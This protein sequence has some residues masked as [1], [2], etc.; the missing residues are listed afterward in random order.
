MTVSFLSITV[1]IAAT[2]TL[3][4]ISSLRPFK[5]SQLE[6]APAI[7]PLPDKV[8]GR[9]DLIHNIIKKILVSKGLQHIAIAITGGP[10][11]G[12]TWVA[13]A[14]LNNKHIFKRFRAARHWVECDQLSP[15][16]DKYAAFLELVSTN[17]NPHMPKSNDRLR[18]IMFYL[19]KHEVPRIVA[20]DNFETIWEPLESR[21]MVE[22]ALHHLA[23]VPRLTILLTSRDDGTPAAGRVTWQKYAIEP[24]SHDAAK[25][26]WIS[27]NGKADDA[28]DD[29]LRAIDGHPL[30][31]VRLAAYA[32]GDAMMPSSNSS[33]MLENWNNGKT[34]YFCGGNDRMNCAD[35]SLRISLQS[36][37]MKSNPEAL[38]LL[39]IIAFLP[40]GIR[41]ENLKVVA[42]LIDDP[43]NAARVLRQ[44]SLAYYRSDVLQVHETTR[45][46]MIHNERPTLDPSHKEKVQAYY[47]QMI[48]RAGRAS[49]SASDY[50]TDDSETAR[51][52]LFREERNVQAVLLDALKHN[53]DVVT[54]SI[55]IN[56]S[57]YLISYGMP[58]LAVAIK[59]ADV[60]RD[61][62]SP[63][64]NLVSPL[65]WLQLGTLYY[66]LGDYPNAINAS[67]EAE[68]G[69]NKSNQLDGVAQ[70]LFRLAEIHRICGENANATH[71]FTQAYQVFKNTGNTRGMSSSLRGL[72][73]IHFENYSYSEAIQAMTDA[74]NAC[75]PQDRTCHMECK[76]ELGRVH[77]E[78]NTTEAIKQSM[79]ARDY[80]L[81]H[82]PPVHAT[83]SLYQLSIPLYIQ[84]DYAQADVGLKEAYEEAKQ[85][86]NH[87]QMAFCFYHLGHL[88]YRQN[89]LREAL[90]FYRHSK[91]M[92]EQMGNQ[93]MTALSLE[94]Q[95]LVYARLCRK[96]AAGQV[97]REAFDMIKTLRGKEK[98]ALR[99]KQ[100]MQ[101]IS[102]MCNPAWGHLTLYLFFIVIFPFQ[103][104]P[105]LIR[106][107]HW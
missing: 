105:F 97:Y 89:F 51:H 61:H 47:F 64:L 24:L 33:Q 12:K 14:V 78:R 87:A 62:E 11:M 60:V 6:V 56:Y 63:E 53:L 31:V 88:N 52:A 85:Q 13:L 75:L 93:G 91:D 45:S 55:S 90:E 23:S 46:H 35:A 9:G 22:K 81:H 42:P 103:I 10:G 17:V 79:E 77:R 27:I 34:P 1:V 39:H 96:S 74:Q 86:R 43:Y 59:T 19:R 69:Y 37:L 101:D 30:S 92:F 66:R 44:V 28:L 15:M 36:L 106:M 72:S 26:L 58:S 99:I 100:G 95:A 40:G 84:Q 80:Y 54:V 71:L 16:P 20:L 67:R 3:S 102:E 50:G 5:F 70:S 7:I 21:E 57:D 82:G 8:Y 98:H 4:A 48:E 49:A 18:D 68:R 65:C 76:R 94:H 25:M 107:L 32:L 104:I 29:L 83:F 73:I 38:T 2:V 41:H